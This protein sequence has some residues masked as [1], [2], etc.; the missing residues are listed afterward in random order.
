[1]EVLQ[2]FPLFLNEEEGTQLYL[3]VTLTEVET[4]IKGCARDKS[5]GPDRWTVEFIAAI[6]DL[7]GNELLAMVEETR[8]T[9]IIPGSLN[10]TFLTF[11]PKVNKPDTF[12]HFRP[13]SL[14]NLVYKVIST[15]ISNC[16]KPMLSKVILDEQFGFLPDRQITLD[17]GIT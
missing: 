9:G 14:C 2:H 15:T 10:A 3:P 1:M 11:I 7:V 8:L 17:I 16:I 5:L 6:F 12:A 13:I 4:V